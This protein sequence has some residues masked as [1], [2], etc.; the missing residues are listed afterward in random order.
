MNLWSFSCWTL[1]K[2]PPINLKCWSDEKRFFFMQTEKYRIKALTCIYTVADELKFSFKA[3]HNFSFRLMWK[4][5]KHCMP[6]RCKGILMNGNWPHL[7]IENSRVEKHIFKTS[8]QQYYKN[9]YCP[10]IVELKLGKSLIW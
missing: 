7:Q 6:K 2:S 5:Q 1:N 8:F 3:R 10:L 4:N 9:R